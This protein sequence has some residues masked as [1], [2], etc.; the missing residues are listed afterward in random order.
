MVVTGMFKPFFVLLYTLCFYILT[1]RYMHVYPVLST[2]LKNL[3]MLSGTKFAQKN[4]IIVEPQKTTTNYSLN[5][6]FI[7]RSVQI[8]ESWLH[9]N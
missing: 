2:N 3:I 6:C 8:V 1:I 7:R 5:N 4:P 9:Y